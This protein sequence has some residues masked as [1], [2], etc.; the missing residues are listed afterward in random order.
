MTLEEAR[1]QLMDLQAKLSAYHHATGAL[2][3]D[4]VTTA[5]RGTAANRAHSM[6]ILTGELYKLNTAKETRALLEYLD[7]HKEELPL[8]ERRMVYLLLKGQRKTEKIPMDFY[9]AHRKMIIEASDAWRRAK[10]TGDFATFE[11]YLQRVFD[12]CVKLAEICEPGTDPFDYWL[13]DSEEG[14]NAKKCDAFFDAVKKT[15]VPLAKAISEK[16]QVDDSIVNGYF[17][18]YKQREVSSYIMDVMGLDKSRCG[19][20]TTEHPFTTSLGS[21]HDVRITT[22]YYENSFAPAMYSVMH[23]G[24]HGLYFMYPAEKFA[25]TVLDGGASMSLHESQSRF[26]ENYVGRS[27]GFIHYIFPRLAQIFPENFRGKTPEDLYRAVNKVEPGLIRIRADEV[28][29]TLHILVRYEIERKMLA[30]EVKIHDVP[31]VWNA[32]YKDYLGVTVPND[33]LGCLQDSHWG[34]GQVGYFPT[35]SLGTAY[36]AQFLQ[37][38]KETVDVDRCLAEGDLAPISAWNREHVWQYG[39]LYEPEELLEKVFEG[40]FDPSVFTRYLEEKYKDIYN[41]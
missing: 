28:T 4:G 3:Y 30:G 25:Y 12:D 41:L 2:H 6:T 31:A 15:V 17:P 36:G 40:P 10:E 33:T 21:Q 13:N 7:G 9:L 37:K 38:M 18:E 19:I 22:H 5:P 39:L 23:E 32:M 35:Y 34:S 14:L 20:A 24:G 8:E 27:R 11:P 1:K 29:Y 26:Y 16:P